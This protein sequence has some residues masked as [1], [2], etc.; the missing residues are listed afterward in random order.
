MTPVGHLVIT[1]LFSA[2]RLPTLL[3]S[4]R[5][6]ARTVGRASAVLRGAG[7]RSI[8]WHNL[9]GILPLAGWLIRSV[10]ATA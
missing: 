7:F 2:L 9:S 6:R 10:T 4:H 8:R 3:A 1:D 5:G